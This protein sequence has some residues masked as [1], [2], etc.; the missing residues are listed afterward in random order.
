M[1]KCRRYPQQILCLSGLLVSMD[2]L[3]V[4]MCEY[5]K[6]H[7][8]YILAAPVHMLPFKWSDY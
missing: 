6:E 4:R 1:L 3:Q 5:H 7:N 2:I 8:V